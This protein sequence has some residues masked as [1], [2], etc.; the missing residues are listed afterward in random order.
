MNAQNNSLLLYIAGYHIKIV[1]LPKKL[2]KYCKQLIRSI[3][4]TYQP[5]LSEQK[6]QKIDFTIEIYITHFEK[7]FTLKEKS[8]YSGSDSF[9]FFFSIHNHII[10]SFY[11]ISKTQFTFLLLKA[12]EYLLQKDKGFILHAS[13]SIVENELI[14]FT[15]KKGA[16]KSTSI[17]L[18]KNKFKPFTDDA[19]LIKNKKGNY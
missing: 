10:K 7:A 9:L 11:H 12:L 19:I 15:G 18:L 5:Y 8:T 2:L 13:S 1:F 6:P 16:G 14:I 4:T 3:N 17:R